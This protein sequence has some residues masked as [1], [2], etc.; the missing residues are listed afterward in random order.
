M[1]TGNEWNDV[2][3]E[4]GRRKR[5]GSVEAVDVWAT[6][7][8]VEVEVVVNQRAIHRAEVIEVDVRAAETVEADYTLF[9]A[10]EGEGAAAAVKGKGSRSCA[11]DSATILINAIAPKGVSSRA[12]RLRGVARGPPTCRGRGDFGRVDATGIRLPEE[13]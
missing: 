1:L 5:L 8:A 2:R 9:K 10:S 13:Q 7:K 6:V 12:S 3:L 4:D 11:G